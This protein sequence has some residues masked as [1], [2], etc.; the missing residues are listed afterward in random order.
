MIKPI[1]RYLYRGVN[2]KL[3]ECHAGKLVPKASGQPFD[4]EACW[5]D[6]QW[7]DGTVFGKSPA[8]AVI[9][10]QRDSDKYPS[11]G[12]ST[13]PT[14]ENAI[15]YA[16]H[17]GKYAT[18]YVYKIDCKLLKRYG[19]SAYRVK[20]HAAVPAIPGDE[21]VI[22]VAQDFGPLPSEIVTEVIAVKAVSAA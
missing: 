14:L 9:Q 1:T 20:E 12:V 4:R 3:Y 15:R 18:G 5:G 17:S 11:S 16:T 13:T 19:V 8:N 6:F 22:L 21:E 10:H 7:G 2:P